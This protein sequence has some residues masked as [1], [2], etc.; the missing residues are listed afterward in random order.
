[1]MAPARPLSIGLLVLDRFNLS[2]LGLFIDVLRWAGD[3]G[4]RSRQIAIRWSVMSAHGE[5]AV[6]SCGIKVLPTTELLEPRSLDYLV[7]AGGPRR[8]R[9]RVDDTVVDY[10]R[11]VDRA[12]VTL[13]SL[14]TE[15][16]MM[17]HRI[18]L[19]RERCSCVGWYQY[20]DFLDEFPG[21]LV[22][23]DRLF[24]V[25]RDRITCG[26]AA[27]AADLAIH[28]IERHLGRARAQKASQMLL[29]DRARAGHEAQPHPPICA[30]VYEPRVR[31]TLILMEQNLAR[32]LSVTALA[33]KLKI[34]PR[35]L[36]RLFHAALGRSPAL[37]YKSVRMRYAAWLLTHTRRSVTDIALNSGFSDCAHFSRAFRHLYGFSPSRQRPLGDA[38]S[39]GELAASRIFE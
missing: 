33:R 18:G 29:I 20:Q 30:A 7:V 4:D 14:S 1:M 17:L 21:Q 19:M 34:S 6:A 26:G 27:A 25:D 3:E 31:R 36:E 2:E 39:K 28:L 5:A 24:L 11:A 38:V 12:G 37:I 22:V 13:V 16:T 35:Q 15:G 10:L 32:P 8:Q 23:A 9:Q